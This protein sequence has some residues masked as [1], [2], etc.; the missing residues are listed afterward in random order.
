MATL[1]R[2]TTADLTRRMASLADELRTA[3][4]DSSS[5]QLEQGSKTYGRAFRLYL[6]D[7]QSGGLRTVPGLYAGGY[8]GMTKGEAAQSLDMLAA[9]VRLAQHAAG[10]R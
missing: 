1:S 2:T 3:G 7:A 6:R 5:L 10:A 4:M 8:L 9:G